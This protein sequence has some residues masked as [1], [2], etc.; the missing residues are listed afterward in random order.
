[1]SWRRRRW[2][3][4]RSESEPAH[5]R[6]GAIT[7]FNLAIAEPVE[8]LACAS[9]PA[10]VERLTILQIIIRA[11][12]SSEMRVRSAGPAFCSVCR[13]PSIT[14]SAIPDGVPS[15]WSCRYQACTRYTSRRP[16]P[17]IIASRRAVHLLFLKAPA[18]TFTSSTSAS[19]PP[20]VFST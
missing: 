13:K 7:S 9:F 17:T 4:G 5:C 2:V 3:A 12:S 11:A 10:L 14:S 20:P 15:G 19:R 8:Q 18:P 16:I 6:P 1:M